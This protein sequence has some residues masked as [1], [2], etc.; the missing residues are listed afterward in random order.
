ME[1]QIPEESRFDSPSYSLWSAST[2]V[3]TKWLAFHQMKSLLRRIARQWQ[4]T[5]NAEALDTL[6]LIRWEIWEA[7][8]G[9]APHPEVAIAESHD[10][11]CGVLSGLGHAGQR[12]FFVNHLAVCSPTG[13]VDAHEVRQALLVAAIDRSIELGWHGWVACEPAAGEE[14]MWRE[15]GFSKYDDF[16]YRRMGY[17][18]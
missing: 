14:R 4:E 6:G 15:L 18:H 7:E 13:D 11:V 3:E 10:Q 2:Q 17:F 5:T 8:C 1:A 12:Y 9:L 16:T